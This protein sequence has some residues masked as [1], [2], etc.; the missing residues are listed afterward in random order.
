MP[1]LSA[2]YT[3]PKHKTAIELIMALG[4][5]IAKLLATGSYNLYMANLNQVQVFINKTI[6]TLLMI[7]FIRLF[8]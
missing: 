5:Y 4:L 1:Q 6:L 2:L 7:W 3:K 8:E